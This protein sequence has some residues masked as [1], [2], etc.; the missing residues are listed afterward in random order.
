[1]TSTFLDPLIQLSNALRAI[2]PEKK[3]KVDTSETFADTTTT[4][5][6]TD[7]DTLTE[8]QRNWMYFVAILTIIMIVPVVIVWVRLFYTAF[9]I[10]GIGQGVFAF[11]L[12]QLYLAWT[13]ATLVSTSLKKGIFS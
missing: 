3:K 1:M 8:A 9:V 5:T 6:T 2:I 10:Q 12:P 13:L 4:T 7:D 11:F